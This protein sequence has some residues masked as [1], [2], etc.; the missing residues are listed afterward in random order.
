M[1]L[2]KT[3][4]QSGS[5]IVTILIVTMFLT[6]MVFALIVQSQ[7]SMTRAR[8]RV[9]LLQAQYAAESGADAALAMLNSGNTSYTGTSGDV[10]VME[11]GTLYKA[12]YSVTV[13]AGATAKE[14]IL[15][16]TGKVYAPKN[17]GTPQ[18]TRN[19][20]VTAQ[21]TSSSTT[22][23]ILTRNILYVVSGVKNIQA[24]DVYVN[25]YIHMNKNT[26]N[27]IAENITVAD[28]NT[29]AAN[30]SIGGSGNLVKPSVF[31][32]PGQTKTNV[33]V[34]F[35][36]CISPPGNT[37]NAN[38]DVLA[39]QNTISKVQSTYIPWSNIMDNTYTSG[40][41]SDWTTGSSPRNIP[42]V[43][44]SKK[45]HYPDS[46]SG[47]SGSCGTS[48]SLALGSNQYNIN[49]NVHIRANLCSASACE[50][51][52]YNP[53]ATLRYVFVEGTI[54]FASL[55]TVAGSGPIVFISYG[56]DTGTR[57]GMCPYGDAVYVGHD[58]TTS[59][60]AAYL[61]AMNGLCLEKTKFSSSPA[62]G[63]LS[64]K[65]IFIDTN[66]GTPFDLYLN[67]SFPTSE[68]PIDLAWR[69][70]RYRRI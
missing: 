27:L 32:H 25:G 9:L 8:S 69:A 37:S 54:N 67:S 18:F 48:G 10:Q 34:A 44:D 5:I 23:S 51:K 59:A 19:I 16:S 63:G 62:L 52:F 3:N 11:N 7:A 22:S 24:V 58:D 47:I 1:K 21:Q 13:A 6:T 65:N 33:T 56:V 14:K 40:L 38:F 4:Q 49:D 42:Q 39:N 35:N 29:G 12:T 50:P 70:M 43:S 68:I 55:T 53:S 28:K 15:T 45:T 20:E 31:T 26:T 60:P 57:P 17:S 66:P 64:G 30:C 2:H 36:N 46:S 61:I 41:C